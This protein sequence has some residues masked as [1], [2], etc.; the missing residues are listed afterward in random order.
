MS[1]AAKVWGLFLAAFCA[2]AP[3][4]AAADPIQFSQAYTSEYRGTESYSI[5]E[6]YE[7]ANIIIALTPYGR[8]NKNRIFQATDYYREVQQHFGRFANHP[9]IAKLNLNDD[10]DFMQF[11]KFRENSAYW[12]FEG[13]RLMRDGPYRNHWGDTENPFS[14]NVSLVEDFARR[15][16]FRTFYAGHRPYYDGLIGDFQ[17]LAPLSSMIAWLEGEFDAGLRYDSYKVI[18]S[19]LVAFSHSAYRGESPTFKES[20]MFVGAPHIFGDGDLAKVDVARMIFTEVDHNFVNPISDRHEKA[21]ADSFSARH[22]WNDRATS[23]GYET[24]YATFNE[25]MTWGTF[26][27]WAQQR[28]DEDTYKRYVKIHRYDMWERGFRQ[29]PHF[30]KKLIAAYVGRTAGQSISDLYPHMLEWAKQ[31]QSAVLRGTPAN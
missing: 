2:V 4:R 22:F 21:I 15:S 10:K 3:E 31:Q 11:I 1:N 29:F 25:Y 30:D 27:L 28:Y 12:K 7:L 6:T 26:T 5:P 24:P 13:D 17:K 9:I 18:F 14:T 23:G 16:G 8:A 20:L 19:P